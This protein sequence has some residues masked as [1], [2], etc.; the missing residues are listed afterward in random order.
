MTGA[1]EQAYSIIRLLEDKE[2]VIETKELSEIEFDQPTED[3][4]ISGDVPLQSRR[5]YT[6]KA[7]PQITALHSKSKKGKLVLQ[8]GT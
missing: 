2:M 8:P 4:A 1:R 3:E 6:D 7:D 5:I